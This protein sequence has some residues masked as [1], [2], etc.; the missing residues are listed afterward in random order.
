LVAIFALA[1]FSASLSASEPLVL[2]C[3]FDE[4]GTSHSARRLVL[5]AGLLSALLVWRELVVIQLDRRIWRVRIAVHETLTRATIE[6]LH[7]LPL[8]YH[9]NE[10]VGG[11]MAKM[12]RGINGAVAAFSDVAFQMIPT[13]AYLAM[14]IVVMARLDWRVTLVVCVF[15]PVPPIVNARAATEQTE[16]ERSLIKR[17]TSIFGRFH[18]VLSG[19]AVVKSFAMEDIEKRRFLAGV[20]DANAVVV[21]GVATDSRTAAVKNIA[22]VVARLSAIACGGFYVARGE[23]SLG[24]LVAFLGYLGALFGPVQGLAG[25]MQT[26]RRG[27][28]GLEI[29][30]S[31]LDT[32][33]SLGDAPDAVEL[34]R[35]RGE[36][37]FRRVSFGYRPGCVVVRGID[38]QVAAGETVGLVG[39]SG[40]GKTTLMALLQ[41][42]YD[43]TTGQVLIDGLDLRSIRQRSLREHI[44]V[45]LQDNMLFSDSVRDN[46]AFGRP[47]AGRKAIERAARHAHAHDF[48]V[49]LPH[50]YDTPVGDR[51]AQLSTGQRQRIAIARALLKDPPILVLDE[52]TSALDAE[53]EALIQDALSRLQQ[54]RTT[55]VIAHRLATVIRTDRILVFHQ[56]HIVESGTHRELLSKDGY[57]KSL[58]RRQTRGLFVDA[59]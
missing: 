33:D 41:R 27:T 13:I 46:I 58:V 2:K 20:G 28:V 50:G 30:F 53:S 12:D 23:L 59:A 25:M 22:V 45:V 37:E 47:G 3:I 16:R 24:S 14:S 43:P 34:H 42:L 21:R 17:W 11:I 38:L 57:Y 44:G 4:L 56:G 5:L 10:S 7:A 19:I 32:Q 29:V 39:A 52:A 48:I 9:T 40:S 18:E 54:G 8:S 31:I 49:Q 51:G 1:L 36:V 15:V 55:F 6:R 26:F 35:V